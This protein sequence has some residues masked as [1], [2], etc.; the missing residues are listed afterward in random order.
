MPL[1]NVLLCEPWIV[2]VS[3]TV[4]NSRTARTRSVR[5]ALPAGACALTI[6]CLLPS[7]T[8]RLPIA[9]VTNLVVLMSFNGF[10]LACVSID[11]LRHRC[12]HP[13][14]AWG[15]ASLRVGLDL[16]RTDYTHRF[17]QLRNG[18]ASR[19]PHL[20]PHGHPPVNRGFAPSAPPLIDIIP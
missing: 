12:I 8:S 9:D 3:P 4:P 19:K 16:A 14:F 2:T 17:S 20:P 6:G 13:P 7:A 18:G 1:L 15:G 11:S 5:D 10:V